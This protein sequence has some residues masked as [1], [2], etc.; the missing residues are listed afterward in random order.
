MKRLLP[1]ILLFSILSGKAQESPNPD[2][3][4]YIERYRTL[5]MD[6]MVRTGVP[7]AIKLAQGI[8][9]TQAGRS[10]LVMR[11]NNHFG[12]KCKSSWTGERTYH[13]DDEKGECFRKYATAEDSWRDHSEFLRTQLRYA[14]LF[15]L[16]PTDYTGWAMGL[17]S[18][19]YA[20]DPRY[21]ETL[22]RYIESYR[23]NEHTLTALSRQQGGVGPDG[24]APAS[25]DTFATESA[26][27]LH[28]VLP[29]QTLYGLSKRYGVD[30]RGIMRLNGLASDSLAA[31]SVIRIPA[32]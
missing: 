21:P 16:D 15:R 4:A 6:E 26:P 14:P 2:V 30:P 10:E 5:A 24:K 13:D 19:G 3:L 11:S 23:L 7:A 31:G 1:F 27:L 25:V 22:I 17:K 12:I 28:R 29:G 9:E 8:I 20:T 32:K 18:A